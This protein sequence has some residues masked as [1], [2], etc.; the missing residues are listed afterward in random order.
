MCCQNRQFK[1]SGRIRK[2][3]LTEWEFMLKYWSI[4]DTVTDLRYTIEKKQLLYNS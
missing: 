3:G 2:L 4:W 1:V